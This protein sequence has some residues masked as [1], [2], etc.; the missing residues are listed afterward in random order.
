MIYESSEDVRN[1][2]SNDES[3]VNQSKK[4][5]LFEKKDV[6]RELKGL[7]S[8]VVKSKES[9]QLRESSSHSMSFPAQELYHW[10]SVEDLIRSDILLVEKPKLKTKY[11]RESINKA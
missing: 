2:K 9:S 10:Y 11:T 1:N 7:Y 6:S 5:W 8:D 4:R 3:F